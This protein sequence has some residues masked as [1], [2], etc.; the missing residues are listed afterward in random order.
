M[1]KG[2]PLFAAILF[3]ILLSSCQKDAGVGPTT[4]TDKVKTYTEDITS[5]SIGNSVTTYNLG[6]DGSNRIISII[7]ASA[8]GNKFLF[9]YPSAGSF[10]MDIYN[11]NVRVIHE[12][13]FLNSSSYPDSTFQYNNTGDTSTEKNIYNAKNQLIKLYEYDYSKITGSDLWNTT[14]YTY[15]ADGNLLKAEDTDSDIDTYE[16]YPDLVYILPAMMPY[17]QPEKHNLVKKH[18]LKS[19]GYELGSATYTYTFDSKNRISTEKAIT[20]DGSIILKTYTYF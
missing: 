2:L 5:A 13:F 18:T 19:N 17:A 16:Y 4:A 8:P 20:S 11:S 14:S 10:S 9:T 1:K 15:D 7:A 6:Y 12:D 3:I